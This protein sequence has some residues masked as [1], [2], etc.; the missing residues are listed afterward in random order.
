VFTFPWKRNNKTAGVRFR[1]G[2]IAAVTV[3]SLVPL[4]VNAQTAFDR[5]YS[6]DAGFHYQSYNIEALGESLTQMALPMNV[7]VPVLQY[8]TLD[9]QIAGIHTEMSNDEFELL[10]DSQIRATGIL[11]G[12]WLM[13]T[14][15]VN[16]PTGQSRLPRDERDLALLVAKNTL[17]MP[18]TTFGQGWKANFGL[19]AAQRVHP[20]LILSLGLS[21]IY[22]HDYR[23][24][25]GLDDV[26][27]PGDEYSVFAGL[28]YRPGL[29]SRFS[30][31]VGVTH[32][33]PDKLNGDWNFQLGK[34]LYFD[35]RW[36]AQKE[37]VSWEAWLVNRALLSNH[38]MNLNKFEMEARSSNGHQILGG[39]HLVIQASEWVAWQFIGEQRV[40]AE[41]ALA[42]EDAAYGGGGGGVLIGKERG[43][44]GNILAKY[45]TGRMDI[46]GTKKD[47]HGIEL[48]G[49]VGYRF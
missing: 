24:W 14:A 17:A 44:Q 40:F 12:E 33:R 22:T 38:I 6:A 11:P 4:T 37:K 47:I 3:L 43:W 2:C 32:Y 23:P 27:N 13:L 49:S 48:I 1:T 20:K 21:G 25:T 31:D 9:A 41:G 8:L 7:T 10:G 36:R 46:L 26:W 29:W 42:M 34:K 19:A 45:M 39:L 16:M 15:G 18:Y 5:L 30:F 35:A 28:D